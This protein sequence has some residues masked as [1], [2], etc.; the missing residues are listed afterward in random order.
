VTLSLI[1]LP[2]LGVSSLDLGRTDLRC[3]PFYVAMPRVDEARR[4]SWLACP[5]C[6]VGAATQVTAGSR[7][8][9]RR[10]MD[11]PTLLPHALFGGGA[12][13]EQEGQRRKHFDGHVRECAYE[14]LEIL[15]LGEIGLV[16][17]EAAIHL[18]L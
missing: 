13:L 16:E 11:D 10:N 17:I 14:L 8:L 7:L 6:D 4:W 18:Q 9:L 3:G 5:S 12:A 2:S 15:A 1:S